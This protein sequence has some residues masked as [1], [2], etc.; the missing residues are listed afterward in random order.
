MSYCFIDCIYACAV[1]CRCL[2]GNVRIHATVFVSRNFMNALATCA[3]RW[4]NGTRICYVRGVCHVVRKDSFVH[5]IFVGY[6]EIK[7]SCDGTN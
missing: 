3:R 1:F 4:F 7:A 6:E 2:L 5:A